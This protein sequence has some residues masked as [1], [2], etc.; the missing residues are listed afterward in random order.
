MPGD[1]W[2][3]LANLRLLYGY[4]WAQ[5]G[6][7]L[8]FMGGELA[9]RSEWNHDTEL[10]WDLLER[11]GHTG[12]QRW[13]DDLNRLYRAEPA[14]HELDCDGAGF[15]WVDAN[16]AVSSVVAFL[17]RGRAGAP[18]LVLCNFTPVPRANYRVGVP[19]GGVWRELLNSDAA[20]YG[21]SGQ[22]N[23]GAIEATPVPF[24]GRPHS[25]VLTLPPL[26]V[27]FVEGQ[28]PGDA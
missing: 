7:K 8:L 26:G 19:T 12:I 2:Q 27:I 17:R 14:L 6:K 11:P 15:E 5:P 9:Q 24:H 20:D 18:V 23:L 13:V 4:Q 28:G 25:L 22:G 3:Q 1:E 21:G 10:E 16:D